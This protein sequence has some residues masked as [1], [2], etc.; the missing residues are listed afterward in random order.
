M[1][2]KGGRGEGM[3]GGRKEEGGRVDSSVEL[4]GQG[5]TCHIHCT[6]SSATVFLCHYK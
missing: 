1:G 5:K 3:E 6:C 2:E 4:D